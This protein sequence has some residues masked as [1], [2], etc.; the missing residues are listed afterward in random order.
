MEYFKVIRGILTNSIS[1]L[2]T[3]LQ[4]QNARTFKMLL[5]TYKFNQ[6]ER[7]TYSSQTQLVTN[8]INYIVSFG[9]ECSWRKG[10]CFAAIPNATVTV[11]RSAAQRILLFAN[12]YIEFSINPK[13]INR[14]IYCMYNKLPLAHTPAPFS[15]S[16]QHASFSFLCAYRCV[17]VVAVGV[18]FEL[19]V[20][21]FWGWGRG[22]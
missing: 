1:F 9:K 11:W 17:G 3:H 5:A 19:Y 12:I 14:I 18:P 8:N 20:R 16:R 10:G 21:A 2:H 6:N 15:I 4:Y 22:G 13:V 7:I